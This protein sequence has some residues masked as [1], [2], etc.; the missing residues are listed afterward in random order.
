M[1]LVIFKGILGSDPDVRYTQ[2]GTAIAKFS[3]AVPDPFDPK[4]RDKTYWANMVVW[5]KLAEVC[6]KYLSKGQEALF[7]GRIGRSTWTKDGVKHSKDEI[8]V[9]AMEFCG[10]GRKSQNSSSS[11]DDLPF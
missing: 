8:T 9:E 6:E 5:G 2:N 4:N 3:L 10:G 7:R 1:N 11:E